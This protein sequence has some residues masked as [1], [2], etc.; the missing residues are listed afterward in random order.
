[1]IIIDQGFVIAG[2]GLLIL[3]FADLPPSEMAQS[4]PVG[5]DGLAA[6]LFHE[7]AE[8]FELSGCRLAERDVPERH[9][10]ERVGALGG[11]PRSFIVDDGRAHSRKWRC[12]G[13]DLG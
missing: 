5:R 13:A 4:L 12:R 11:G 1:M 7:A 8:P 9:A 6:R 10:V 3:G 2:L